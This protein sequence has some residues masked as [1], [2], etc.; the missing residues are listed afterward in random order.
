MSDGSNMYKCCNGVV[1]LC[2]DRAQT[3]HLKSL[4]QQRMSYCNRTTA[5]QSN[6]VSCDTADCQLSSNYIKS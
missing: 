1:L 3:S 6:R 5:G 4:V 2:S